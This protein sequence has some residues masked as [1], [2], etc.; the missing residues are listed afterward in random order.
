MSMDDD[1]IPQPS[2]KA[3]RRKRHERMRLGPFMVSSAAVAWGA[4]LLVHGTV[5][6]AAVIFIRTYLHDTPPELHF[7]LGGGA[8]GGVVARPGLPGMVA[9]PD[10]GPASP[11]SD[12]PMALPQSLAQVEDRM[13]ADSAR[14]VE[15]AAYAPTPSPG[16]DPSQ[17][18]N[19]ADW[20]AASASDTAGP[21]P[22]TI[23][24]GAPGK[25]ND[26][27]APSASP[28]GTGPAGQSAPH[29]PG[30]GGATGGGG[31]DDSGFAGV[32][33][34]LL[35]RSLPSPAYPESW[36]RAGEQGMVRLAV[37][38]RMDGSIGHIEVVQ[39][40]GYPH[41]VQSAVTAVRQAHFSPE[42]YRGRPIDSVVTIPFVF[43][44]R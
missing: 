42:I 21:A 11:S 43:A 32:P 3:P 18:Q 9:L 1:F 5:A 10:G 20:A 14:S 13:D 6:V 35:D 15:S 39:D 29:S 19:P 25:S 16:P 27:S 38:I 31:P 33:A 28:G 7:A 37:E 2:P 30:N 26:H 22:R 34:G 8:Q 4:S 41:L 24:S 36:R 40:P 23:H 12:Q 17:S 44:L